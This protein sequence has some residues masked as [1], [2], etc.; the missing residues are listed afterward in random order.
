MAR[1]TFS[2]APRKARCGASG[3]SIFQKSKSDG[4]LFSQI[5]LFARAGCALGAQRL[6]KQLAP[7]KALNSERIAV[8]FRM[9]GRCGPG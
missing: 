3:G 9:A 4:L 7:A 5:L 2:Q 6:G 1:H 8:A